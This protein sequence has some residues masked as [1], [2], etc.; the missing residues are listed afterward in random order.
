MADIDLK[1][2]TPDTSLPTDGFL[3]GADSQA[4][5][6]PS[7]FTTQSVATTLLGSTSL[8][9]ATGLTTSQP[10][11]D[12]SQ[13]WNASGVTFTGLRF[14]A[15][16]G[17]SAN[18]AAGSLLMDLQLEGSSKFSVRKDG[19]LNIGELNTPNGDLLYYRNG[20]LSA[21]LGASVSSFAVALALSS[22]GN[23]SNPDVYLL[24]KAAANLQLGAADAAGSAI[25]I[26]S[27]TSQQITLASNH[28]LSNGAAVQITFTAG[29]AV[30]AG[31]AVNTTYYARSISAAVLELYGTYDQAL[32]TAS[33][34]GRVAVTTAGTTAFVNRAAPFQTLSVQSFTGTD[35]PGQPFVITGSQG[36]GTGVGGSIIFQVAPAGSTGT[37]QNALA[38]ALTIDSLRNVT[39][40]RSEN[41]VAGNATTTGLK[42]GQITFSEYNGQLLFHTASSTP[43]EFNT[44]AGGFGLGSGNTIAW[45]N[46]SIAYQTKD[47]ILARDAANTLALRNGTNAQ[48]FNVYN[49]WTSSTNYEAFKIDWITT[50]NTVL[51]GTEKGSGGGTARALAFQTDGTTALT[52]NTDRSLTL[53]GTGTASIANA[54]IAGANNS[55]VLTGSAYVAAETPNFSILSS[56]TRAFWIERT[57]AQHMVSGFTLGWSS[58]ATNAAAGD[59][60]ILARDAANTLAL[61]NGANAQKFRVY[62]SYTT[63]TNNNFLEIDATPGNGGFQILGKRAAS[64]TL[65][66]YVDVGIG[67]TTLGRFGA[68]FTLYGMGIMFGTDNAKDIG[69][70]GGSRPRSIF[71]GTSLTLGDG[72]NIVAQSTTGTKIGTATTQKI[73]FY[74]ATP[75]VQPTAVADA[76]DAATVI[77]QLNALLAHMRTL[78]LIAT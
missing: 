12:L 64:G 27:V 7:V 49:T 72:A 16:T 26:S 62:A 59:D 41:F 67:A 78:G 61:R 68:D 19:R 36:T 46:T 54:A 57:T 37:A 8:T 42:L 34:T 5:S 3:F 74:N 17:S 45:S 53:T 15:A 20:T 39:I 40:P 24:R 21:R 9:G 44:G 33:T 32:N 70:S 58:S 50:A 55:L 75:V 35:I 51:V 43:F 18:S 71:V 13:T 66:S 25:S 56:G 38:T 48:R 28:G 14:N 63:D 6:A 30:P 31:T 47:L 65:P 2:A 23:P 4:A 52:I 73:G 77:T 76:T 1:T 69:A 22:S 10:V 11:L 60:T 29:G